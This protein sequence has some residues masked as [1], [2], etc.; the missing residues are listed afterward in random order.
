M[1]I[2]GWSVVWKIVLI[3]GVS[4]FGIM[5][6]LVIGGGALDVRKLIKRLKEDSE[7]SSASEP[8]SEEE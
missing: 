1:S 4:L 2:E 8:M 3:M 5:A 7:N 6:V